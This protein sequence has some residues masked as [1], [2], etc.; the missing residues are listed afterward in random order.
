MKTIAI[1][2]ITSGLHDQEAV[3]GISDAFLHGIFPDGGYE[4]IGQ[5]FSHYGDHPLSL[6]YIRTGGAER[7]N[8]SWCS[9]RFPRS[10][11]YCR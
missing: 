1:Y 7:A 9:I 6:I 3:G 4:L 2:T 11:T 5:D 10:S 8:S